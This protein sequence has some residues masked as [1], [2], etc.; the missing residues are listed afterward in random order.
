MLKSKQYENLKDFLIILVKRGY[1]QTRLNDT[2][3]YT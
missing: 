3:R 2:K 1:K